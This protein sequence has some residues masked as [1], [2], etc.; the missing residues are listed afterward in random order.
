MKIQNI[1]DFFGK[2]IRVFTYDGII[3]EGDFEGYNY[4]YDGAGNE[5]IEFDIKMSPGFSTDFSE[6]EVTKIEIVGDIYD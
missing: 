6:D 2:R 3:V 5:F 4:D 1:D